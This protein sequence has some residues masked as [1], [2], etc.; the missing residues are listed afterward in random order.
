MFIK[1]YFYA[2]CQG[3]KKRRQLARICF[4]E[5]LDRRHAGACVRER[6]SARERAREREH[7]RESDTRS[8]SAGERESACAH[9]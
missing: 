8:E 1:R 3:M 2:A 5:Q 7:E 4:K 9:A 6:K